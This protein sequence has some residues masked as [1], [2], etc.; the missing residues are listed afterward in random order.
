MAVQAGGRK[1]NESHESENPEGFTSSIPIE[2]KKTGKWNFY[3]QAKDKG[4]NTTNAGPYNIYND[5]VSDLPITTVINPARNMHVQGNLNIMGVA[6]DDDGVDFVEFTINRGADGKGEELVR[7]RAQGGAFWSYL[8]DTSDEEIWPDGVYSISAWATDI[9]GLAGNSSAFPARVHKIHRVP[10]N[11]DRKKP[12]TTITSHEVGDLVTGKIHLK[13]SVY[14]GNGVES[15]RYSVDDGATYRSTPLKRDNRRNISTFDI[16]LETKTFEDGPAVIWFEARDGMGTKG[17]AAHLLFINNTKPELEILYPD[18]DAAVAGVFTVAAYAAHPTGLKA[19]TWKL[20]KS[21]GEFPMIVGNNWWIQEFDIRGQ[22]VATLDLEIR[23]E[24][25][26]GNVTV[27]KRKIKVDQNAGR[28]R[29]NLETPVANAVLNGDFLSVKGS[30]VVGPYDGASA[31]VYSIDSGAPVEVPCNGNFQ[32]I[33]PDFPP[34]THNLDVWAKDITGV[35][36]PKVQVRGI[37]AAGPVPAPR[38]ATIRGGSI[39]SPRPVTTGMDLVPEAKMVLDYTVLSALPITSA[40]IS[41]NDRGAVPVSVKP[42]KDNL[43]RADV[44]LPTDLGYGLV[45]ATLRATDRNGR[46]GTYDEYFFTSR[47][48]EQRFQWVRP[49]M[50]DDG[51]ILIGGADEALIGLVSGVQ[52]GDVR[53]SGS[54]SEN[55]VASVNESGQ[56]VL[57]ARREGTFGPLTVY[58]SGLTSEPFRVLADFTAP[59]V[60]LS[61]NTGGWVQNQVQVQFRITEANRLRSV[62]VS[63]N[64][65]DTWESW[66]SGSETSFDRSFNIDTAPDGTMTVLIRAIDEAGH[67]GLQN[68][69]VQ[70]DSEPPEPQLIMPIEEAKVNGT[71]RLGIAIKETGSL[72]RVTYYKPA[73]GGSPA[74]TRQVY[75]YAEGYTAAD[76]RFLNILMDSLSMPLSDNMRFTFED[77]A[78]NRSE[79]SYWP[80]VIDNEMDVP[81]AHIVLPLEDEVITSDFEVSGVVFDDDAIKQVYWRIDNGREQ[82]LDADSGYS[83]PVALSSMTDNEHTVTVTAEDIY[84][85][86]SAPVTRKFRVSLKEPAASVTAPGFDVISRETV[87]IRGRA[88]DENGIDK[89]LISLDNGNSFNDT[90]LNTPRSSAINTS[91]EW[92]YEFDSKILKDGPHAVFIKAVDKYEIS[93]M[94][95]SLLNLD[96]TPPDIALDYPMDGG[97]TTGLVNIMGAVVDVNLLSKTVELRSLEGRPI[98]SNFKVT[99]AGATPFLKE[100]FDLASLRDG[101]YNIEIKAIDKAGNETSVSR[102]IELSR[103]RQTNFVDVLYP[104]SG[105]HVQGNFVIYGNT[106]GAD[107][108]RTVTLRVNETDV[109]TN[110]TT[111]TGYYSFALNE[112]YL[113]PGWNQLSVRSNFSSVEIYGTNDEGESVVVGMRAA[114]PSVVSE[115]RRIFYKPDGPWIT[116]DSMTMGDF[117]YDRAWLSGRAGYTLNDD[118]RALIADKKADPDTRAEALDKVVDF[119][120]ISFDNGNTFVKTKGSKSEWRYRLEDEEMPEGYHY[121][122]VRAKMKN[123]EVAVIRTLVQV[124]KTA[125]FI[126]LVAPE[127]GGR[128]NQNLEFAA[129]AS[130]DVELASLT[131]HLRVGDKALYEVPGFLQGLYFEA[132]IPPFIRQIANEAPM[133]FAG[134][135]TYMDVGF[136]LSFFEDNVK[137]Q[138][139]YGFLTQALYESLGGPPAAPDGT[140]SVRYGGNV[141]GLKILAS[142]YNLP[143][144]MLMGPDWEWLF[145]TFAIG[146]NFSLFDISRQGYTQSGTPTWMSALLLQME[147]PKVT[148]PK[149]ERFRTF[150]LFTEGQLWFVP[151]DVN[152]EELGIKTVIPH[153]IM[154]LRAYVF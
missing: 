18:P 70:K 144:K 56:V 150:S 89:I 8:V 69:I 133:I 146:A 75:P 147:F 23:A 86:K 67:V 34:G 26:S 129:M 29:V 31:V 114:A 42:G 62:E 109:I 96:N 4:G 80:F 119:I 6:I 73:S 115:S 104:L 9:N 12:A 14:D 43:Y 91:V 102:N 65:G 17:A 50:M 60:S 122:L 95:S 97:V 101:F 78:G 15:L 90:Q 1:E 149:K 10:W 53:V 63:S 13:G 81:V 39:R 125:P 117:A 74:I 2:N 111:W 72:K 126:R 136:G 44:P 35:E 127:L 88:S 106:G 59:M 131:Y 79:L 61:A 100:T 93:A 138:L 77:E 24:D 54:G 120:D 28:L 110:D 135:A 19:V 99:R 139:Q 83:I 32:F 21:E 33:I 132:T 134:G 46:E 98:P 16:T 22:K 94:Y 40:W 45:K 30:I 143:F 118:D 141:L 76:P 25:R 124:D 145:A 51:R 140:P 103:E 20:G 55:L 3:V 71:I 112:E 123:G 5:P 116:I 151:T 84:G 11:L 152:A 153:I 38:L 121:I 66:L 48:G 7:A 37:F 154:G 36:G 137:I 68:I 47:S 87:T 142:V 41:F 58:V 85:V 148:I 107:R 113:I 27:A 92:T 130:D 105:E 52:A 49:N 64:L 57:Q 108:S 128:Y 82:I